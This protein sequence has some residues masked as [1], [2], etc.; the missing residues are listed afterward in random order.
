MSSALP[1]G[2]RRGSSCLGAEL[3]P[4]TKPPAHPPRFWHGGR[5]DLWRF[6]TGQTVRFLCQASD[7]SDAFLRPGFHC[8]SN[9]A[10]SKA[11]T[12]PS[13]CYFLTIPI[14]K[15]QPSD[16]SLQQQQANKATATP[17]W[18]N[19]CQL[20]MCQEHRCGYRPNA[21]LLLAQTSHKWQVCVEQLRNLF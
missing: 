9:L 5:K 18:I 15:H 10:K 17:V 3:R 11:P 13:C 14:L 2:S 8:T 4:V 7:L 12:N 21:W 20:Q 1:Q 16:K 6:L 19:G